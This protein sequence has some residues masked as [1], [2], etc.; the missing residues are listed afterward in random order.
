MCQY[1]G[2]YRGGLSQA[3][4]L[5]LK[6]LVFNK[7]QVQKHAIGYFKKYCFFQFIKIGL[8]DPLG[9]G[10]EVFKFYRKKLQ[11]EPYSQTMGIL[12]KSQKSKK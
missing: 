10:S 4:D 12:D 5:Q 7:P 3:G 1:T 8:I 6:V 2:I 11:Y 9:G